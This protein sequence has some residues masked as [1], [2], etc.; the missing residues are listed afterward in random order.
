MNFLYRAELVRVVDGDTV[1]L[2]IDLGFHLS[3]KQRVRLLGIDTPELR[4]GT[5]E[6][7]AAGQRA[8]E[9]V[10]EVLEGAEELSVQTEKTGKFGRW[11]GTIYA[12]GVNVNEL[13]VK[14][15]YAQCSP[16]F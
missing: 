5:E 9:R 12:D 15:G 1:D 11:L 10:L 6:T 14:E 2:L 7:K 4:G 13:L 8:R 16:L 3:T